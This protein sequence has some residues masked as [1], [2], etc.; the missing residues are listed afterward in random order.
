MHQ[1]S[2]STIE[3]RAMGRF[4]RHIL[5]LLVV[6]LLVSAGGIASSQTLSADLSFDQQIAGSPLKVPHKDRLQA[7]YSVADRH[8]AGLTR[9]IN[10]PTVCQPCLRVIRFRQAHKP[11][12]PFA[13]RRFSFIQHYPESLSPPPRRA[14]V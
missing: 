7:A 5:Y 4:L 12:V 9:Q 10:M 1:A 11:S 8:Q 3:S 2:Q 13:S 14:T 6:C